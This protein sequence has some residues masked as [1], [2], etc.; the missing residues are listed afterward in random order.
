MPTRR[1]SGI[2]VAASEPDNGG[3][4]SGGGGSGGT[5][6]DD[7]FSTYLYEGTSATQPIVKW[8]VS[9]LSFRS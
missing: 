5:Y 9:Q 3:D 4:N 1:F 8:K 7:V 2:T 6:V